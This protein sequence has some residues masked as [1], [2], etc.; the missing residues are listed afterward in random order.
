MHGVTGKDA[1][2]WHESGMKG[3][4]N[5]SLNIYRISSRSLFALAK[6]RQF[7]T[8]DTNQGLLWGG[9]SPDPPSLKLIPCCPD[10][11]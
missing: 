9:R 5:H 11:A 4:A 7:Y 10:S 1:A 3:F 2:G 8:L 6:R